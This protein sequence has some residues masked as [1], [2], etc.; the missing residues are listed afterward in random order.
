MYSEKT[1]LDQIAES[2]R[3]AGYDPYTQLYG[4]LSTGNDSYITRQGNARNL[5]KHVDVSTLK[6][7]IKTLKCKQ[8]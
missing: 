5:I 6:V 7:F 4:Y 3:D 2:I 8:S 1:T